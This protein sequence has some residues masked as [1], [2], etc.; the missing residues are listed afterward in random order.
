M[1]KQQAPK[2]ALRFLRW[3]CRKD[4]LE[5]LEGDLVEVFEKRAGNSPAKAKWSFWWSVIRYFRPGFI[6]EFKLGQYSISTA[7]FQNNLK[8]AWRS[9][10]RQPFFTFL[11]TFGL[12]IG[13]TGGLLITL[14]I[15]DELSYDKM[16]PGAEH[17]YRVQIANRIAGETN[18]HAAVSGPLA[19]VMRRDYPHLEMVTRFREVDSRLLKH[20]DAELNV[21]E[22]KV[23]GVDETFFEMFG[24]HLLMGDEKTALKEQ[25]SLVLTREAAEKHFPLDEAL[26]QSLIMDNDETYIVTGIVEDMP[27]NSFL[28]NYQV[29]ISLT[30]FED[31]N[32]PAWNNWSWP[33]FVKLKPEANVDDF[34][35]YLFSVKE[36]YLI[37]WAMQF[38]PGLTVESSRR[39]DEETGNF[40]IFS[41]MPLTDIHLHS[42][43]IEGEF[44]PNGDIQNIYILAFIGLFLITLASVNFMNLSTA[45]SLNRAKEVGIRKTLGSRRS[46]LVR[47]FLTEAGVITVLSLL[48]AVGLAVLAL[49]YFNALA[50]KSISIP[51]DHLS[52]WLI[53]LGSAIILALASGSYPAFLLSS[54]KTLT[55]LRGRGETKVG[56]GKVRSMLVVVQFAI[57]VFLIAS[58]LVVYQQLYYIQNKYLG[59]DKEQVLVLE[60]V[61]AAGRQLATLKEEVLRIPTVKQASLSSFLPTPSYRNGTTFFP[62]G[63]VAQAD[64][65]II[66]GNWRVDH[67]YIDALSL[68]VVAGRGFDKNLVTDS[69]AIILN[70]SAAKMLAK[71]IEEVIGMRITDDFHREDTENMKFLTVIGVVRNFHF[72]SLR[73]DIDATSLILSNDASSMIVKLTAGEVRHSIEQIKEKWS[74]VAPGQ[75]FNYYFMD[76]S[77]EEVYDAEQRLG[78]IFVSFT[79][80]SIIVASLGLFGLAAFNAEKK[81][82][83]IGIRKV[84]GASVRQITYKL[85][86]DFLKL[87]VFSIIMSIPLAWYAMTLWL[88]NFSYRIDMPEWTFAL[89]AVIAIAISLITISFQSIKAALANP[90]KSLRSE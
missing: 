5:E 30:S 21:K 8:V 82:K 62:E 51:F 43:N 17:I 80:L 20:P 22:N 58:T 31:R 9:L 13:I 74:E 24:I 41:G 49:P 88:R 45:Y 86:R 54:F 18:H 6:R 87:V 61:D 34:Q 69:A 81:A 32:S 65:A 56:G 19:D 68:E 83:E 42:P 37:P 75:P 70:E 50:D 57:A 63:F 33:T 47:Q 55:I 12:A 3:F 85:S 73:N 44:N 25:N 84:L 78:K 67:D 46:T 72:E 27:E 4:Y 35:A 52:F 28:R 39:N 76:D 48:L 77:F 26:G 2:Y 11:N 7:M 90:V 38:V 66:I 59:Y 23:V 71:N 60:D 40:M 89:A 64:R 53:L 79:V 29:F 16:F 10:K 14:F 36:K 15:H 1:N